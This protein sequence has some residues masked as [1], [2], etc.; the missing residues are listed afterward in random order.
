MTCGY[1]VDRVLLVGVHLEKLSDALLLALGGVHNATAALN[2]TRVD[3]D[4]GEATKEWVGHN[5]EGKSRE[6]LCWVRVTSKSLLLIARVTTLNRRNIEWVWQVVNYCIQHRLNT[7]VL[8]CATAQN[9]VHLGVDGDLADGC[10]DFGN[11][12]LFATKVLFHKLVAGLGNSLNKLSAVLVGLGLE[13]R[14]DLL[15]L[16]LGT[17]LDVSTP[18]EGAHLNEVNDTLEVVLST[19]WQLNN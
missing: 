16:V 19:N 8:E 13:V 1:R 5:L 7:L 14:W 4:V 10:L 11:T 12:Q 18:G 17:H 15:N 9:W 2:S 6:W 3:A